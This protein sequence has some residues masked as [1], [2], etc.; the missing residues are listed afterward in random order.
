MTALNVLSVMK[1]FLEFLTHKEDFLTASYQ[2]YSDRNFYYV[3]RGL[4]NPLIVLPKYKN[5]LV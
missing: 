2:E 3:L 5:R 4:V 1:T